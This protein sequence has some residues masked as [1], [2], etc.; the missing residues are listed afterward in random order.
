MV[1]H[2]YWGVIRAKGYS[3][4]HVENICEAVGV[5]RGGFFHHFKSEEDLAVSAANCWSEIT[6]QFF[7]GA[8]YHIHADPLDRDL[9]Y[10]DFRREI[11]QSEIPEFTCLMGDAAVVEKDIVEAKLRYAPHAT[12]TPGSLAL[13]TQA[14]IQGA[15]IL[16]KAR[17]GPSIAADTI[18][19]LKSYIELLF[20]RSSKGSETDDQ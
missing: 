3:A 15:F 14:V 2:N 1:S 18:D 6:G 12:W 5:T 11:L 10:I 16:T 17:Q 4:T 7:A 20:N 19:H 8:P 13:H 9:G